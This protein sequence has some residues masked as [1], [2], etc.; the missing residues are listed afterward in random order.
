MMNFVFPRELN[1]RTLVICITKFTYV[2]II[3]FDPS[4]AKVGNLAIGITQLR[5]FMKVTLWIKT[6]LGIDGRQWSFI[7]MQQTRFFY[8]ILWPLGKH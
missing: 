3:G 4:V 2:I 1:A 8:T 6:R 7:Q 5:F